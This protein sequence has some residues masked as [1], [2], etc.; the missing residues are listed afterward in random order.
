MLT[1]RC[2]VGVDDVSQ[3]SVK[4]KSLLTAGA[5]RV[6]KKDRQTDRQTEVF[7]F[8]TLPYL[9]LKCDQQVWTINKLK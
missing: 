3:L 6:R 4:L 5:K 8:E 7:I 9:C 1:G 2:E